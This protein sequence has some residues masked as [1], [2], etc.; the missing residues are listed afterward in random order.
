MLV[1][2]FYTDMFPKVK[3]EL[4]WLLNEYYQI[5]KSHTIVICPF[6]GLLHMYGNESHPLLDFGNLKTICAMNKDFKDVYVYPGT[7]NS[8]YR[9]IGQQPPEEEY[10]FRAQEQYIISEILNRTLGYSSFQKV[11][12]DTIDI[13]KKAIDNFEEIKKQYPLPYKTVFNLTNANALIDFINQVFSEAKKTDELA[14]VLL[15]YDTDELDFQVNK[16]DD[17]AKIEQ[18][19]SSINGT[20]YLAQNHSEKYMYSIR[21]ID[22]IY[23][24]NTVI[25]L[26]HFS[27]VYSNAISIEAK[28]AIQIDILT[29]NI[30]NGHLGE[31]ENEIVRNISLLDCNEL[32]KA[33]NKEQIITDA[34]VNAKVMDLRKQNKI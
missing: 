32:Y 24:Y 26:Q 4:L 30:A 3:V 15:I 23:N 17:F 18:F 33:Y 9:A 1:N 13:Y 12:A 27:K 11:H 16:Q 25:S 2:N 14:K 21:A 20:L 19:M 10:I 6:F 8:Y 5:A 29:K 31:T 34:K 7:T 28:A 22:E